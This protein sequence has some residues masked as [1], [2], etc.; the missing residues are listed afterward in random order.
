MATLKGGMTIA[1][2]HEVSRKDPVFLQP[3]E[4]TKDEVTAFL[5]TLGARIKQIRKQKKLL[6]RDLLTRTGYYDAQ[7]RKYEAG[8]SLTIPSLLKV[9]VALQVTM[10]ELL[11]DLAQWPEMSVTEV[12]RKHGLKPTSDV[13]LIEAELETEPYTLEPERIEKTEVVREGIVKG[14][15]KQPKRASRRSKS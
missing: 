13:V 15:S 2:S 6:M 9:A 4:L 8:G 7:W 1:Q 10:A 14:P 12:Q 11:D 3:D 5:A